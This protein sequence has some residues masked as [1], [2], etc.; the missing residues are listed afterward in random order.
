MIQSGSE[1]NTCTSGHG[2]D[3]GGD[4][5]K[6]ASTRPAGAGGGDTGK[7][8]GC[9]NAGVG[10][11]RI[12]GTAVG[13]EWSGVAQVSTCSCCGGCSTGEF[14]LVAGGSAGGGVDGDEGG[15]DDRGGRGERGRE[16]RGQV[17][18]PPPRPSAT[19]PRTSSSPPF[20]YVSQV[21]ATESARPR[22]V[23]TRAS[24]V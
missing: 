23:G 13:E 5:T 22:L 15:G 10:L 1:E 21:E 4:C 20:S 6:T 2:G 17:P 18:P 9:R 16:G 11:D 12:T 14:G 8:E 24:M 19:R 7:H 3:K